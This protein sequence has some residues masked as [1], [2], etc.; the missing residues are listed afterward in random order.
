MQ[1]YY[2]LEGIRVLGLEQYIA[3][4]DCTMWLADQGAEVIKIE[5]PGSGDPRRNYLPEVEDKDG[6]K[7]YGGFEVFNRN[8]KSLSLNIQS[9]KGKALFKELIKHTDVIVENMAPGTIEKLG[10]GYDVLKEIN[11]RLIYA[12]I[13]GFGRLDELKGP[14][15]N[16]PAFDPVIQAM[17]GIMD[18]IGEEGK[19][20]LW[21]FPG[22][23]D[24]FTGVVT[25]Y[26]ILLALFM[27]ERT[28]EG[29][30]IDSSMYDSLVALNEMGIMTYSFSG[31]ILS[32]GSVLRF[33]APAG[34]YQLKDGSYVAFLAANDFIWKRFCKAIEREDL[35]ENPKT[36]TGPE[37]V[38]NKDFLEPIVQEWMVSRDRK[39]VVGTL[40]RN[41]VPV[42]PV[43][44]AEDLV[45]CPHLKARQML[46]Q[47]EHPIAGKRVYAKSPIRMTKAKDVPTRPSPTLGEHTDAILKDL[48][49]YD[50]GTIQGLRNEDVI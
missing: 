13:S 9:E 23:A 15:S 29:Q 14:Y 30:F 37:R 27:R 48:L 26:A 19:P 20:P 22:L 41:G 35:I 49:N 33:Q 11:P 1:K 47:I 4:P 36:A 6:N 32:R 5:R 40:L 3:G 21:G 45:H 10:L 42:G 8:K 43:Q 24:M 44:N 38:R 46:V 2:P 12:A 28:G 18:L 17:A 39:E 34:A 31:E 7:A 16:W 50:N 25:G